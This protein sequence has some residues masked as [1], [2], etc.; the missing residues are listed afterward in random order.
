MFDKR[1]E[2]VKVGRFECNLTISGLWQTY[3]IKGNK[4]EN[5]EHLIKVSEEQLNKILKMFK[6]DENK[7]VVVDQ[8]NFDMKTME[9]NFKRN[10]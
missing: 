5:K 10:K 3:L 9:N 7:I 6:N 1:D 2:R 8:Q 4:M